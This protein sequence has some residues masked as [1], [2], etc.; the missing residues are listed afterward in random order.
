MALDTPCSTIILQV[1][2]ETENKGIP[3]EVNKNW[4]ENGVWGSHA[5]KFVLRRTGDKLYHNVYAHGAQPPLPSL[6]RY[7]SPHPTLMVHIY[8]SPKFYSIYYLCLAMTTI[9][10]SSAFRAPSFSLLLVFVGPP[11]GLPP[12]T[13]PPSSPS[14]ALQEQSATRMSGGQ[15]SSIFPPLSGTQTNTVRASAPH[16]RPGPATQRRSTRR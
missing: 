15:Q 12:I 11:P 16:G 9:N 3:I 2:H 7:R 4:D 8:T 14:Q 6:F 5:P 1:P 10:P 13:S